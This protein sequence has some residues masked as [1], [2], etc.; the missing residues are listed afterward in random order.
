MPGLFEL[1]ASETGQFTFV[2]KADNGEIILRSESYTSKAAA[3]KGIA[4]V[5]SHAADLAN[6]SKQDAKDGS[7]YFNLVAANGEII[8]TSQMYKSTES[9]DKGI[10]SIQTNGPST[11]VVSAS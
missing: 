3:E 10:A 4:S 5:Q 8:G 7:F 11:T 6:F 9:R 2:L 1:K